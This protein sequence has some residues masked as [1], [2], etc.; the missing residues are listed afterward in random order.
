M[1]SEIY[2]VVDFVKENL[3]VF[4]II[5]III[6]DIAFCMGLAALLEIRFGLSGLFWPIFFIVLAF[7]GFALLTG[8]LAGAKIEKILNIESTISICFLGIRFIYRIY[9]WFRY[10]IPDYVRERKIRKLEKNANPEPKT[11]WRFSSLCG[12][13]NRILFNQKNCPFCARK[14]EEAKKWGFEQWLYI[15]IIAVM[16]AGLPFAY[17]LHYENI[18]RVF[19]AYVLCSPIFIVS[20]AEMIERV[21]HKI[22]RKTFSPEKCGH[23]FK[24][25]DCWCCRCGILWA[26]GHIWD[27]TGCIC[28]NCG[29]ENHDWEFTEEGT[30]TDAGESGKLYGLMVKLKLSDF[31]IYKR[32]ICKKCGKE[33]IED[34]GDDKNDEDGKK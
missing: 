28:E 12:C 29:H 20:V 6:F 13:G 18:G 33:T 3:I 5:S 27:E 15:S 32:A 17:Y 11:K 23:K 1:M 26:K 14:N 8:A 31:H 25:N 2:K 19:G 9:E 24:K 34:F 7:F 30:E 21:M 10:D 22:K 4:Q 16:C